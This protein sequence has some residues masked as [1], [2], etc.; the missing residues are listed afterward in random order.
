MA[1]FQ[2]IKIKLPLCLSQCSEEGFLLHSVQLTSPPTSTRLIG[3]F[4]S[5]MVDLDMV[6]KKGRSIVSAGI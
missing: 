6:V 2:V 3:T 4:V 5:Y 1:I